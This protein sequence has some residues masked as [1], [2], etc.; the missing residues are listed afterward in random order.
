MTMKIH[1]RLSDGWSYA[2]EF[3]AT[4]LATFSVAIRAAYVEYQEHRNTAPELH[5]C[6]DIDREWIPPNYPDSNA[7]TRIRSVPDRRA[8]AGLWDLIVRALLH[9]NKFDRELKALIEGIISDR[10]CRAVKLEL[11]QGGKSE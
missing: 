3:D 10:G 5:V 4:S 2:T 6:T 9:G 8:A 1:C 7:A 11:L